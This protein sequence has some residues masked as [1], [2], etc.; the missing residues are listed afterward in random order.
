MRSVAKNNLASRKEW[1]APELK[2]ID[3]ERITA[4]PSLNSGTDSF[5]AS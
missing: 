3:I 1:A 5:G 2:K 4:G